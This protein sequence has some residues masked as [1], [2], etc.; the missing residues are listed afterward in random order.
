MI[1]RQDVLYAVRSA[2][3][4]PLLTIVVVLALSVGIGLNA[5][6]FT[7]LDSMFLEPPTRKNPASF[8]QIYPRYQG[9]YLGRAKDSSFNAEDY[10]AIRTGMHSLDDLAAWQSIGVTLDDVRHPGS[11]LLVSCNYFRVFG[12]D[13]PLIGRFFNQDECDPGRAIRIAV[14]SE[15]VWRDVYSADPQIVGKLIHISRQPLTVVGI[16][17]DRES[18]VDSTDIWIPYS[19]Q[20]AFNHGRSAFQD[21]NWAWLSLAGRLR[22]GYS[23]AD[24]AAE[25]QTIM[26]QCDRSYLER[27]VFTLDRK[28]ELILTDGSFIRNPAMGSLVI[29]LMALIM[30]PLALVLLL[31]CTNVTMLF[32]SRSVVRRGEIAVRIALGAGR[33]RLMRMLALESFL[34]AAAAGIAS[35][36]L[37]WRFPALLFGFADPAHASVAA[38]IHPDWKVFAFLAV[39]VLIATV[40]SALAPMRESFKFDLITALKGREGS[41]TMR[42]QTTSALIVVQLAMSFVL[43]AAA[44]LFARVPFMVTHLNPGFDTHQVMTVPLDIDLPPYTVTSARAFVRSVE[45]RI[46]QVPGVQSLAWESVAPF[47]VAPISEIRLGNQSKGQGRVASVDN[48]SADFFSTFGIPLMYGRAFL[49][50]DAPA[51]GSAAVAIVSQTFAKTFWG[52]DSP[53]GKAIVTPDSRRLEVIGIAADTYSERFGILDGPR[54][55][56]LQDAQSQNGQLFVRFNGDAAPVAASIES[57]ITSIDASQT[58]YPATIWDFLETNA[59]AMRPLA[60]IILFMAGVAVVLAITAS[61]AC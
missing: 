2:R 34:T 18:N 24:A 41:A 25:I 54:L 22:S 38:S 21:A 27:R 42:S 40:A 9:W 31:A 55:Y 14:L 1:D 17:A 33:A 10:D 20:P 49:H 35:I 43:L 51:T 57:I 4:T 56:T 15:H 36:Y 58:E 7:I 19:L 60:K 11:S 13:R 39:L 48:V 3:R 52:N 59:T 44:V 50:S 8:V 45:S 12:V 32:L 23:R 53:V 30:G 47:N 37:A 5:G 6:V 46:L 61:M 16:V 28:T 26:R 29:L